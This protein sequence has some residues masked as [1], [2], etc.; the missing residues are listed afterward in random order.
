MY[1]NITNLIILKK[2]MITLNE[3]SIEY[4]FDFLILHNYNGV[5]NIIKTIIFELTQ[6]W[7]YLQKNI[8]AKLQIY[9]VAFREIKNCHHAI[10]AIEQVYV[11]RS[12]MI[13][14]KIIIFI[15]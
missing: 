4:K 15:H 12:D 10:S 1:L 13:K 2:I 5:P 11:I 14:F 9:S 6:Q 8:L 3:I 7:S